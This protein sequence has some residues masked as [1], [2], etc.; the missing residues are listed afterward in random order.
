MESELSALEGSWQLEKSK[1]GIQIYT[2]PHKTSNYRA[3]RAQMKVK[4]DMN[5]YLSV[6][7]D[8]A[9][10]KD[11]MHTTIISELVEQP[12]ENEKHI[13]MVNRNF[14]I[15]D[16]DYYAKVVIN[17]RECGTI[18]AKWDLLDKPTVDG[19]VR[20]ENLDVL[21]SFAPASNNEF[22]VTLDGHIEP[23]GLVP[24]ALA[25]AFITDVPFHTFQNIRQLAKKEIYQS[26][27]LPTYLKL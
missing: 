5:A 1:K 21:I 19:R 8:V 11:W 13:Y 9:S 27:A 4:G 15:N 10:Y 16:R 12:K 14:P 24:A 23:G 25:N 20:V 22:V 3:Y 18:T 2:R 17:Q 26:G 7:E 6:F